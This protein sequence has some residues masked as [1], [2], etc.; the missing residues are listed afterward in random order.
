MNKQEYLK[1]M[2]KLL[3]ENSENKISDI[4][5][6]DNDDND[7]DDDNNNDDNDNNNKNEN[8]NDE[9]ENDYDK[10]DISSELSFSSNNEFRIVQFTRHQLVDIESK[11]Y[12][13]RELY[14]KSDQY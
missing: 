12:F 4:A 11:R 14:D 2:N 9:N 10:D 6:N 8:D 1:Y 3:V 13:T 7:D 5:E